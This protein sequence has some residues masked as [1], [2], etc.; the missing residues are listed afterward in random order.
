[1]LRYP[2]IETEPQKTAQIVGRRSLP[3]TIIWMIQ[4][5]YERFIFFVLKILLLD[6]LK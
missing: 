2:E 6:I 4:S 5:F 3:T 1:M